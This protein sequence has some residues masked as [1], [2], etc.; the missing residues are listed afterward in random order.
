MHRERGWSS[1]QF[2]STFINRKGRYVLPPHPSEY[3]MEGFGYCSQQIL[4][5]SSRE[6][7]HYVYSLVGI[8]QNNFM[9]SI[10][11]TPSD[12]FQ[13]HFSLW[14]LTLF[15]AIPPF[16]PPGCSW[17]VKGYKRKGS[18]PEKGRA[19]WRWYWHWSPSL[20]IIKTWRSKLIWYVTALIFLQMGCGYIEMLV[21]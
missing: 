13:M 2:M 17:T 18:G 10:N 16:P 14:Y 7:C 9:L 20:G 6:K 8:A 12:I 21:F 4:K 5:I 15:H 11:L 3:P 1:N 19:P